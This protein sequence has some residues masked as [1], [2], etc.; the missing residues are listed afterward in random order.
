VKALGHTPDAAQWGDRAEDVLFCEEGRRG[1][2]PPRTRA[3]QDW[4]NPRPLG[5]SGV[6]KEISADGA[7]YQ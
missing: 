3:A 6:T 4:R 7:I 2:S 1:R 5:G